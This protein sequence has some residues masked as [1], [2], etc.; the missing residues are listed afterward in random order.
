MGQHSSSGK[1]LGQDRGPLSQFWEWISQPEVIPK[2]S[3]PV[4]NLQSP[5]PYNEACPDLVN[6]DLCLRAARRN[7]RHSRLLRLPDSLLVAIM[8]R[9][10]TDDILWLRHTS[11]IF[12]RLFSQSREFRHLHLKTHEDKDRRQQLARVWAVPR[13]SIY[14]SKDGRGRLPPLCGPCESIK[15]DKNGKNDVPFLY[16]SGVEQTIRPSTS[17][18]NNGE[19]PTTMRG[20]V[21][22]ASTLSHYA[23]TCQSRGTH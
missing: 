23:N 22:A 20:S 7:H 5:P 15:K 1:S 2:D 12:M 19:G 10:D 14:I 18:C 21:S 16:C 9:L 13:K 11:R 3:E 4:I 6:E 17:L 8:E